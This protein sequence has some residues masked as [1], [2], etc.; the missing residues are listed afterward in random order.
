MTRDGS[1]GLKL[2]EQTGAVEASF[3]RRLRYE[4]SGAC[5]E[6]LFELYR[7]LAR[8][9]A[10]KEWRRR[11]AYGLERQDFEQ[12]AY[13]GL[14]DA[15]NGFDPLH[16]A[17]FAAFA[18]RRISGAISD[19]IAHSSEGAA[20]YTYKRRLE[21]ER[22]R[23]LTATQGETS[24]PIG[25]L[26][27]LVVSL[28]LGIVA[29]NASFFAAEAQDNHPG[30]GAYETRAWRDLQLS[31][32]AEIENLPNAERTIL[33]QHYLN[34]VS[35][36]EIAKLLGVSKSR[37]SQLHQAALGRVRARLRSFD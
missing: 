2:I 33:Q 22:L 37:V 12:L 34:D 36:G 9:L 7:G 32:L 30:L 13:S 15:I 21:L 6:R 17:P 27:D 23:S 4:N 5:R 11:P 1:I 19:G 26:A 29:E 14:L 16:G 35:F 3:W 20:I 25:A 18:R 10:H 24:D 28:A 8:A 31:V